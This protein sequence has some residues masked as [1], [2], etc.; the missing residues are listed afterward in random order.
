MKQII[1]ALILVSFMLGAN[2]QEHKPQEPV[3]DT[4][5]YKRYPELPAFNIRK[6]DSFE[7]FNTFNI[8]KGRPVALVLFDPECSHCELLTEELVRGMDSLKNIDFY[9]FTPASSM[10]AVRKFH[11]NHHFD[12]Y[13]N[14]KMVGRDYEFF[15]SDYYDVRFVPDIALY[16]ENKKFVHLFENKVT[17]RDLYEYTHKK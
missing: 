3:K 14:I 8:P 15:F 7:V 6:M 2:G 4:P 12:Q 13:P 9:Y 10:T 11:K 5:L 16:D 17:V 1:F